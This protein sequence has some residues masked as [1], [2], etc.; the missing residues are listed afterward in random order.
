MLFVDGL[1]GGGLGL[2]SGFCAVG[3]SIGVN[4]MIFLSIITTLK[5]FLFKCSATIVSNAVTGMATRFGLSAVSR[6]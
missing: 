3:S 2:V 6:K 5:K 4:C 1:W